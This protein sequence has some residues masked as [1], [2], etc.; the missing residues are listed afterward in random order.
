MPQRASP[1]PFGPSRDGTVYLV[2][3]CETDRKTAVADLLSGPA[4]A[5]SLWCGLSTRPSGDDPVLSA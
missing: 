5:R 2:M 4:P 1:P 3:D